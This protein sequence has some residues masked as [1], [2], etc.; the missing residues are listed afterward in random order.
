MPLLFQR[1]HNSSCG[2]LNEASVMRLLRQVCNRIGQH[3]TRFADLAFTAHDFRRLF[4]TD[5]VNNGVPIHIGAA[6]L[7]HLSLQTTSGY[8]AVFNDEVVRHYQKFLDNRRRLRP[9]GEYR[10]PTS[11]EWSEFEEHFDSRKVELG[12]CGR[13]YASN[14]RH[15]HVPL[16][17]LDWASFCST[18]SDG[19]GVVAAADGSW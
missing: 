15:E 7:G 13:P 1:R 6:L 8:V 18:H 19:M 2:P 14:C 16:T 12:D 3:D 9:D 5:L 17:E 11:T 10:T 4:A